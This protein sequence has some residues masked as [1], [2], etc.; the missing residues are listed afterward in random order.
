MLNLDTALDSV[1]TIA[2]DAGRILLHH[3]ANPTIM[4]TKS[5]DSDIVTIADKEAEEL[6]VAALK[7][8]FP[9]HHMVGEEGGGTGASAETAEYFWFVDPIDGTVNYAGGMPF[10]STSIALTDKNRQPILGVIYDPW[11]DDM[12]SAIQ[13]QGAFLN[14]QPLHVSKTDTLA[15][16]LLSSGFP[17]DKHLQPDNNLAEWAAFLPKVRDLRRLGSAALDLCYVAAARMDGYWEQQLNPWD[18]LAGILIVREAGGI[19]TDYDGGANPQHEDKGKYVASNAHLHVAM[20][21]VIQ[22]TRNNR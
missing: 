17:Y 21:E 5:T 16:A 9:D 10:F 8:H 13:G 1:I 14:G 2:R 3:F 6:I 4:A 15:K 20:L 19:V 22:T 7:V 18:V 12:F 11:R